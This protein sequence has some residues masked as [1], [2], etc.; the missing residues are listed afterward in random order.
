MDWGSLY[1]F[2]SM[3]VYISVDMEGIAGIASVDDVR[4]GG[5]RYERGRR[6]MEEEVNAIVEY[7]IEKGV[8][9]ITVND[10][11]AFA[12]NLRIEN[13][14]PHV[15]LISGYPK[16]LYM[17]EG[18][19]PEYDAAF[20]IGY[21]ASAGRTHGFLDHTYSSMVIHEIFLNGMR[22]NEAYINGLVA[23]Y[24]DVP[25]ALISGDDVLYE[26]SKQ[27]FPS[28]EFVVT[29]VSLTR[30]S[31]IL[32]HPK[33]VYREYKN[34][35]DRLMKRQIEPLPIPDRL[36][37]ELVVRDTLMADR[38]EVAPFVER[39]DGYRVRFSASNPIEAL[40]MLRTIIAVAR[41]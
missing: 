13:L 20:F 39:M 24:Y 21:H 30:N 29:K 17:M 14:H 3:K 15:Q 11:H 23:A 19:S 27:L 5:P 37:F 34:A 4:P 22:L 40:K 6:L 10:S 2:P 7:L 35:I 1:N 26:E 9:T 41:S 25:V 33:R 28:T 31:A 12:D 32:R 16:T 38:L 36:E 8:E 18:I